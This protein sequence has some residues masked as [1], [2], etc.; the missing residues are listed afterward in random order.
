MLN[1]TCSQ[2]SLLKTSTWQQASQVLSQDN[3]SRSCT[4][5]LSPFIT[6]EI[7]RRAYLLTATLEVMYPLIMMTPSSNVLKSTKTKVKEHPGWNPYEFSQ[8]DFKLTQNE[9]I[10]QPYLNF[11]KKLIEEERSFAQGWNHRLDSLEWGSSPYEEQK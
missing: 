6:R 9:E 11:R 1:K 2:S 5:S 8:K 4:T 3:Y 10:L 7:S